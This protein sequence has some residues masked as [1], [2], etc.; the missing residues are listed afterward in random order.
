MIK[1]LLLISLFL[2]SCTMAQVEFEKLQPEDN[3]KHLALLK[4]KSDYAF[5]HFTSIE[6]GEVTLIDKL[7]GKNFDDGDV[8]IESYPAE[9]KLLLISYLNVERD[10]HVEVIAGTY[11]LEGDNWNQCSIGVMSQEVFNFIR[12][13]GALSTCFPEEEW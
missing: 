13:K 8:W 4:L 6:G 12:N 1:A 11:H 10:N 3:Q 2:S 5:F 9:K 7:K